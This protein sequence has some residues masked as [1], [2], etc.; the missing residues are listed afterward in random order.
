MSHGPIASNDFQTIPKPDRNDDDMVYRIATVTAV[1]ALAHIP[2]PTHRTI[3][4]RL[5]RI[6]AYAR[7]RLITQ[8]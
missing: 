6:L 3:R 7:S 8:I 2:G 5:T 4:R 1:L